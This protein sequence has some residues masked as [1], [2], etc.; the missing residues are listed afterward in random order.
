MVA[1]NLSDY[2]KQFTFST[3]HNALFIHAIADNITAV[4]TV[5]LEQGL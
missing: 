1:Q 3:H 2:Y 5:T 4:I